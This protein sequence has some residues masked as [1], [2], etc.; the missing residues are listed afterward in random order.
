M[1]LFIAVERNQSMKNSLMSAQSVLR[2]HGIRGNYTKAENLHLTLA[3]IGEYPDPETVLDA[4][5]ET[6]FRPFEIRLNGFG[7]FG[8]LYWIG[9]DGGD[10]LPALVRRLRKSLA[11]NGIPF[12]RKKFL[13]HITL[14]RRAVSDKNAALPGMIIPDAAM[15]VDAVSLMRSDRGKNGMIYTAIDRVF[16][17]QEL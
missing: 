6:R 5:R 16:A 12:D 4:M 9:V 10:A 7:A 13:P 14:I 3:F 15:Q 2:R 1:R 8:D 11:E 17:E